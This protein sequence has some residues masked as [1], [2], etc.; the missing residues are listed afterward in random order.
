MASELETKFNEAAERIK[1]WQPASAPPNAEKLKIYGLFKQ[2][3]MG[4]IT[5]SRPGMFSVEARAKWDAWNAVK[6]KSKEEAM[7]AYI[8]EVDRQIATYK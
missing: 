3:T 2:A 8:A 4:D 7:Q 1:G 6:G 5:G